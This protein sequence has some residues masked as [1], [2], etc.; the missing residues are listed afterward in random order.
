M[1]YMIAKIDEY[2]DELM[3]PVKHFSN[4][5]ISKEVLVLSSEIALIF[6]LLGFD[7]SVTKFIFLLV[8]TDLLTKWY[9]LVVRNYGSFKIQNVLRAFHDGI[10]NSNR[11]RKG[12]FGKVLMYIVLVAIAS[13]LDH[14]EIKNLILL[15]SYMSQF[16]YSVLV[17]SEV[18][19]VLENFRD[20][21]HS[22]AG[23]LLNKFSRSTSSM[24][25]EEPKNRKD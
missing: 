7:R 11:L 21:G 25:D 6:T 1:E 19:S 2:L 4:R 24:F 9:S 14:P 10:I 12:V 5:V 16:I 13:G 15:S 20:C 3:M 18:M 17:V 22:L 23:N 8:L